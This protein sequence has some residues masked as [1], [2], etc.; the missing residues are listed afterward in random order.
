MIRILIADDHAIM[1]GGL[2]QLIEFDRHL[3]VV[4]EAENGSQVLERLRDTAVDLLLL[5]M[6]MPGLSGEDLIA[7]IRTHHAKLPILV[8]SMHNEPQI[9]QR[10]LKAGAAGYLTKDHNPETLLAVIHRTAAGGRYLDPRIAEQLAFA[11]T[12]TGESTLKDLSDREYQILRML[13]QGLSVNQIAEHLVIS[14]KTVSTHKARLME[15][16]GFSCNAE[17]IKYAMAQGLTE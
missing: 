14:N 7:R 3:Q 6:S 10:A 4:A 11:S 8:L 15:K 16:M 13:A 2:K 17:I 5:D 1:R 12:S 9:A